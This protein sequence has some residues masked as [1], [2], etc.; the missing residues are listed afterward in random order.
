MMTVKAVP[1]S[2]RDA[3]RDIG[4]VAV[5]VSGG[6]DSM[7]LAAAA[8]RILPGRVTMYHAVSPAVPQEATRRVQAF[9]RAE[10]WDLHIIDAGEFDRE[11][12]LSNPVNRCY[13]CKESL[14]ST[15]SR[16]VRTGA[17][18]VSG[19][20]V[21]D[22]GEYRPGLEAARA[23][24]VRHPFVEAGLRKCD[25]RAVASSLGLGAISELA[26][27]PCL[28]SR[29]ETGIAVSPELL[30]L[31]DRAESALRHLLQLDVVRCRYRA[32]GIVIELEEPDLAALT[33]FKR[34]AARAETARIFGGS[35]YDAPVTLAAYRR[36]SAFL[37]HRAPRRP[38]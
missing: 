1:A 9:A 30:Q 11:D 6:V 12:Y 10:Q 38:A 13:F 27:S 35:P 20:N 26:A 37:L 21:D 8:A 19:T 31:V 22:L 29:V 33:G 28:A 3:L 2:L 16:E 18:V 17:Q 23:A 32:K 7:T 4:E 36:G 15:I 14:Y 25:V 5:A 24:G 34:D